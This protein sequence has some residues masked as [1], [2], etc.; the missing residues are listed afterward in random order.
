MGITLGVG[1]LQAGLSKLQFYF[2]EFPLVL[3]SFSLMLMATSKNMMVSGG[4]KEDSHLWLLF[5]D[6]PLD[7]PLFL[8]GQ[9]PGHV[10]IP[11][12]ITA[13]GNRVTIAGSDQSVRLKW[14]VGS[15]P[16]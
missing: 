2:S 7:F 3:F 9:D 10:P 4:G 8:I 11:K 13:K 1:G 15:Q 12:S 5:R 14:M 6:P 16:R